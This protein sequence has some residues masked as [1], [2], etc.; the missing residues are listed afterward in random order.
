M[1]QINIDVDPPLLNAKGLSSNDV[2]NALQASNLILPA[3][4]A[5]IGKLEYNVVLNSSPLTVDAFK[6][7]QYGSSQ[8]HPY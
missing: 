3:G 1:R 2:V 5:R 4:I 7:F 6:N 8:P